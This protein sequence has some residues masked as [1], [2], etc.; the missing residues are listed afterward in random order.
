[1]KILFT[2]G[3]TGGHFYPIIAVAKEIRHIAK[4]NKMVQPTLLYFA[5]DPYMEQ[6]LYDNQI[7]F[8][9][10]LAGKVRNYSSVLN[11]FDIFKTF[12]GVMGALW[13]VFWSYPDVIFSKG[14][15]GSF[16]VVLAGRILGIPIIIHE[17]DS[18]PG[19][20]NKWSGKFAKRI[21]IS[22]PDAAKYFPAEKTAWT[23][24]PVRPEIEMSSKEGASEYL[25]LKENIPVLLILG[26]S[27]GAKVINDIILDSLPKL[28]ERF[29]IIHQTGV[30][31]F[32]E[33]KN[34]AESILIHSEYKNRYNAFQY[35]DDLAMRM[36]AG[37]ADIVITRAGSTIFEVASW[38]IPSI[39]IPI[40][41]SNGNHQRLN[42]YTYARAGA[43]I[44]IEE[45]NLSDDILMAQINKIMF[46]EDVYKQM[47][48][49][50]KAFA[51]PNADREIAEEILKFGLHNKK[52]NK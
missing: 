1:M 15:Y 28:I 41:E 26:G 22:Y 38:G 14:G 27:Q 47:V 30:N 16:P 19:K 21:A 44:V 43:G 31:N 34:T 45:K 33:V 39:I 3:G 9:P 51:K 48:E 4:E 36:S 5:P 29:Q 2:G 20:V 8:K 50:S 49:N 23:G 24:N 52:N 25:K 35:L 46:N 11:F 42:A 12:F 10:I 37:A 40:T 17:S 13:K 18:V 6:M 32:E 7:F